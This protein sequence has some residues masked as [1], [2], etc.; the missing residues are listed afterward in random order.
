MLRAIKPIRHNK[1]RYLPGD[2]LPDLADSQVKRL[3]GLK[4]VEVIGTIP[5]FSEEVSA[6]IEK[7]AP[8]VAQ[9]L[10]S[11]P[12]NPVAKKAAEDKNPA[13]K[14]TGKKPAE[15]KEQKPKAEKASE[16]KATIEPPAGINPDLIPNGDQ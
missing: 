10:K 6:A 1:K 11:N 9:I 2:I 8:N 4:A 7:K 16:T 5:G 14:N 13:A 3:L 15:K 12:H